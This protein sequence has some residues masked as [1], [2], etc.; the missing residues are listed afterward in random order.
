MQ[1]IFYLIS[2]PLF[3]AL[4][5]LSLVHSYFF[6]LKKSQCS[7]IIIIWFSYF[8]LMLLVDLFFHNKKHDF[9]YYGTLI[10]SVFSVFYV[11]NS[12]YYQLTAMLQKQY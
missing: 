12:I 8:I 2:L 6:D 10:I 7:G 9:L 11:I 3:L 4:S 1:V 5:V